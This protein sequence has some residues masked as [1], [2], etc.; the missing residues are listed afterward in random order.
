MLAHQTSDALQEI[1]AGITKVSDLVS[2][3]NAASKEQA[4]GITQINQ[5]VNQ[6]DQVTQQNTANAE[7]SAAAAQQ[8]SGQ[9]KQMRQMLQRFTLRQEQQGQNM[10]GYAPPSP[11]PANVGW[12]QL[13]DQ[14]RSESKPEISLNDSD[15]GKY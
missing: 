3:I 1:V 4:L 2:E 15:F 8:L 10:T 9:A 12:A 11:D 14:N 7:E 13:E 5:G 6:V